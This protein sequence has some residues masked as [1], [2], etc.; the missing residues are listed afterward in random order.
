[1]SERALG[2]V[3]DG[4]G[5]YEQHMIKFVSYSGALTA[6]PLILLYRL[7]AAL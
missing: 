2:A 4:T 5:G 6:K 1:M 3:V 7:S